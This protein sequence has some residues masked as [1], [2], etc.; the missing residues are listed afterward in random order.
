M[1]LYIK[2][3]FVL[4]FCQK[5]ERKIEPTFEPLGQIARAIQNTMKKNTFANG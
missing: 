3:T 1:F 5:I 2:K 4:F